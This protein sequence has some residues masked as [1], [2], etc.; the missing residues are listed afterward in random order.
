MAERLHGRM[1][2]AID[3]DADDVDVR[4]RNEM[5]TDIFMR[6]QVLDEPPDV[7][8]FNIYEDGDPRFAKFWG[9]SMVKVVGA[10]CGLS[11]PQPK[12]G[13]CTRHASEVDDGKFEGSP[14]GARPA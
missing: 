8:V 5:L 14:A 4:V 7:D 13:R 12:C 10:R 2:A 9:R 11:V 3:V 1:G 6:L